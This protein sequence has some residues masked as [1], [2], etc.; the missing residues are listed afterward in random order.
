[1]GV[2]YYPGWQATLPVGKN[3]FD[4]YDSQ[5]DVV[6]PSGGVTLAN[7]LD[8]PITVSRY[9]ALVV[10]G[11]LSKQQRNRGWIVACESLSIGATGNISQTGKGAVGSP[12]WP[13]SDL[14]IPASVRLAA[15]KIHRRDVLGVIRKN[16]WFIGD[17]VLMALGRPEL[18]DSLGTISPGVTLLSAAGCGARQMA[19]Q[20]VT[21]N[22]TA[23]ATGVN[24][25]A[26]VSAPGS[27]ATSGAHTSVTTFA[28]TFGGAGYPW[29]GGTSAQSSS[30]ANGVT[31]DAP[32]YSALYG[33][34]PL[35]IVCRGNISIAN[36]GIVK[37]DGISPGYDWSA[38][39]GG[40]V[41]IIY[42]GTFTNNGTVRAAGG[43]GSG[44]AMAY[45][46]AGAVI[47]KTFAQ[48]GW[49]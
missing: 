38:A 1:M 47:T 15:S 9:G 48:M 3:L 27:A 34:A 30:D 43:Q 14:S 41:A 24:G 19:R 2:R 11:P 5:G 35:L 42:G 39:G 23:G 12:A 8:G 46:G 13:I 32:P 31:A 6:I 28:T 36:G 18:A 10:N 25:V 22:T 16:N 20:Y 33:G 17:P 49:T 45:S 4:F 40:L 29:G 7:E 21:Y 44:W 37:S 26:G